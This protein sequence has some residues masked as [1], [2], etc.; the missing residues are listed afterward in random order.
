MTRTQ[1]LELFRDAE[2]PGQIQPLSESPPL[3]TLVAAWPQVRVQLPDGSTPFAEPTA[4]AWAELWTNAKVELSDVQ[5][6][7]A[8]DRVASER[9]FRQAKTHRLIYPDG[10]VHGTARQFL[11]VSMVKRLQ[12]GASRNRGGG[13]N[14]G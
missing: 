3:C 11:T 9:L 6:A 7:L 14:A 5:D 2:T 12:G 10:S 4:E 13:S 8:L 1:L